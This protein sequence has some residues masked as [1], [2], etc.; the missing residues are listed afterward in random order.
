MSNK[1]TYVRVRYS[2]D[3]PPGN[4]AAEVVEGALKPKSSVVTDGVTVDVVTFAHWSDS[5][6]NLLEDVQELQLFLTQSCAAVCSMLS[7]RIFTTR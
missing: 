3:S 7:T 6:K 5:S 4:R 1:V 2:T